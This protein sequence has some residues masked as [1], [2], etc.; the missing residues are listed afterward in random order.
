MSPDER[1]TVKIFPDCIRFYAMERK[2]I[3][4][5]QNFSFFDYSEPDSE[6]E[7]EKKTNINSF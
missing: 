4:A 3:F 7:G 6:R 1:C 2:G 5:K